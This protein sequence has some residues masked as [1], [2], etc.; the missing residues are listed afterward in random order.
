MLE[1]RNL[2]QSLDKI[3]LTALCVPNQN[4]Q[5]QFL[6]SKSIKRFIKLSQN[7]RLYYNKIINLYRLEWCLMALRLMLLLLHPTR[8][9][10]DSV[11][12]TNNT[13]VKVQIKKINGNQL[14]QFLSAVLQPSVSVQ[15]LMQPLYVLRGEERG[16]REGQT[17]LRPPTCCQS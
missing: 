9:V 8:P 5:L 6:Y 13:R 10:M 2:V 12:H 16:E 11:F 1:T 15:T 4:F 14:R 7:V 3:L 17:G